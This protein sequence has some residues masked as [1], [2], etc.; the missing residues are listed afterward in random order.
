MK[1]SG[2]FITFEG[3]DG[4]GKST[5]LKKTEKYLIARGYTVLMLREPGSTPL[6]ERIRSILLDKK[7]TI[8]D[9]PELMLYLA[10]RAELVKQII[11]PA[12]NKGEIVLC[13]RFFDSTTAY[14]GYG[15]GLDINLINKL[16]R[17]AVGDMIPNLTLLIDLNFGSSLARRK[18]DNKSAD[19]LE[20]ESR[21]FFIKVREGFLEIARKNKS[22]VKVVDGSPAVE[23]VFEEV[24]SW[25]NRKLKI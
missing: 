6:S 18:K 10:A 1:K 23:T 5:Q 7:L 12:I 3:I 20:S 14:Q 4:C 8:G 24:K 13:D 19:R 2:Y 22:R 11:E 16:N 9:I 21:I 15:R 25:L 17:L